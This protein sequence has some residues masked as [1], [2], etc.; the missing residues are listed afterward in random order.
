MR[1]RPEVRFSILCSSHNASLFEHEPGLTVFTLPSGWESLP[2]PKAIENLRDHQFDRAIAL[3]CDTFEPIV[4]LLAT[5][6]AH[7]RCAARGVG[8]A[9]FETMGDD[10]SP[11]GRDE[12]TNIALIVGKFLG[13][14]LVQAS[15]IES[16]VP[17]LTDADRTEARQNLNLV[18]KS[19]GLRLGF[20]PFAGLAHRTPSWPRWKKFL[21]RIAADPRIAHISVFGGPADRAKM[22]ELPAEVGTERKWALHTP[23]SFRTIAAYFE[24]LD[25][26]IAV[27]SGPLHLGRAQGLP[28]LGILSGGDAERWFAKPIEASR[29][30]RR[31]LFSRFPAYYEMVR[32]YRRWLPT[33]P[34]HGSDIPETVR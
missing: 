23:S 21:I 5:V 11:V 25:G 24:L 20:C 7:R 3:P 4:R 16:S 31:G 1:L 6:P 9:D 17:V 19:C 29:L 12:T 2:V 30:V 10:F 34:R 8:S 26:L 14:N 18:S 15:S 27:D 33:V 32:A 13:S 28:H 22:E